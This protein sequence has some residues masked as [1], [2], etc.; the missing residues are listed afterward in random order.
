MIVPETKGK[1]SFQHP[2]GILDD[3]IRVSDE[4]DL[5]SC[6]P[7][8]ASHKVSGYIGSVWVGMGSHAYLLGV[9]LVHQFSPFLLGWTKHRLIVIVVKPPLCSETLPALLV[10]VLVCVLAVVEQG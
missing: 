8:G 3:D 6:N 2:F 7:F 1:H 4:S 5:V 9:K 10:V